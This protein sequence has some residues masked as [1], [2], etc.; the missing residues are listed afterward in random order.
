MKNLFILLFL[1]IF[2]LASVWAADVEDTSIIDELGKQEIKE[3]DFDFNLKSFE[4][5]DGLEKVMWDYVKDYWKNNK[6]RWNYPIAYRS[7]WNTEIDFA[8][9]DWA[10]FEESVVSK[11]SS[12]Q[13]IGWWAEGDFSETNVQV[14]GVDE[15]DIVKTDWKYIY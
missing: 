5:C 9:D 1:S 12:T 2:S 10:N 6:N 14:K 15:S 4:T 8:M 11:S 13:W 7:F 3:I